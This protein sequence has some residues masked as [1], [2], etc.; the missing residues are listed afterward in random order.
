MYPLRYDVSEK[1]KRLVSVLHGTWKLRLKTRGQ[2]VLLCTTVALLQDSDSVLIYMGTENHVSDLNGTE[3]INVPS[4]RATPS[5][6][7][8]ISVFPFP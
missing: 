4:S 1:V 2:A 5:L 3:D 8:H 6:Q 7:A